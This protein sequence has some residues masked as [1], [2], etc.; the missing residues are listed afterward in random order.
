[1]FGN[2]E[3]RSKLLCT[4]PLLDWGNFTK[5]VDRHEKSS[6]HSDHMIAAEHY[7]KVV[8]G[9]Q[10]DIE[11][12]LFSQYN[13]TV[14]KNRKILLSIVETI[15]LCGKQNIALR[16]YDEE[17]GNFQAL[18]QFHAK[19]NEILRTHLSTCSPKSKYMSPMVQNELIRLCGKIITDD[20]I[21]DCNKAG[22][23]GF[24]ADKATDAATVEQMA[25]CVRFVDA[26]TSEIRE[27]FL[28]F[29]ATDSIT[30]E[31]LANAF[32]DNLT[33]LGICAHL[34]WVLF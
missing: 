5:V 25:M 28:G 23:F 1:M 14:E 17:S 12:L 22:V 9:K 11:C 21:N 27:E 6:S 33:K 26:T 20:L 15:I 13:S 7:L 16:G 32:M 10:K 2:Q 34:M 31:A 8:T 29:S 3:V 4:A 19:N 30:G 24:M 18:L